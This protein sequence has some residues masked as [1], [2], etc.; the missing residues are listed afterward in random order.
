V[1][2]QHPQERK[3]RHRSDYFLLRCLADVHVISGRRLQVAD[4]EMDVDDRLVFDVLTPGYLSS[5]LLFARKAVDQMVPVVGHEQKAP[6]TLQIDVRRTLVLFP[7]DGATCD[8]R[9]LVGSLAGLDVQ[10]AEQDCAQLPPCSDSGLGYD[11]LIAIDATWQ[12][13][14]EM[15][16]SC[17]ILQKLRHVKLDVRKD[18]QAD[19]H[20]GDDGCEPSGAFSVAGRRY[21][22]EFVIRKPE[23]VVLASGDRILGFSTAEAVAIFLSEVAAELDQPHRAAVATSSTAHHPIYDAVVAPLRQYVQ[24]QLEFMGDNAKHRTDRPN[25]DPDLYSGKRGR[26]FCVGESAWPDNT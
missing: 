7:S 1:L 6:Q 2:L 13:A 18:P 12:F 26:G 14:K 17:P 16:K 23:A 15:V 11:T 20:Q 10:G 24:F 3:Q 9:E 4:E 19:A 22:T 21:E 5:N 8:V 25:Y